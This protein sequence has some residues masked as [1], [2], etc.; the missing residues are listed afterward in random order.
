MNGY[1][2]LSNPI[3][4]AQVRLLGGTPR[5][6]MVSG[7]YA[8]LFLFLNVMFYRG[9]FKPEGVSLS[10]FAG[11]SLF[12]TLLIQCGLLF[13]GGPSA[14]KKAV[15]RDFTTEMITSHR[16]TA[17]T[18]NTAVLGYLTGPTITVC[19]LSVINWIAC[20]LLA[21]L[22]ACPIAAPTVIF[23]VFG[24]LAAMVWTFAVLV[25]LATRGV[26]SIVGVL[27]VVAIATSAQEIFRF[28]P[29]LA[30]LFS[31][32]T[33]GS[34]SA[35]TAS[36]AADNSILVSMMAQVLLAAIFF[37]AAARKFT[38]DDVAA[39]T[40][41]L[42]HALLAVCATV[43]ALGLRFWPDPTLGFRAGGPIDLSVQTVITLGALALIALLPVANAARQSA[44]WA[45]R[46]ALDPADPTPRPRPFYEAPI[47]ATL[48]VL[49]ILLVIVSTQVAVLFDDAHSGDRIHAVWIVA[50]FF[51]ALLQVAGL[52]RFTYAATPKGIWI[53]ALF[54][55]LVWAVPPIADV[56]LEVLEE[57]PPADPVSWLFG[58]SPVGT[59]ILSCTRLPGPILPGLAIQFSLAAATL[60]LARRARH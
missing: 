30:L 18:G 27:V 48:I 33:V 28:F 38:R 15:H 9:L 56:A 34:L 8:G 35:T 24:C 23:A 52:L 5:L 20:T 50:A 49:S 10:A 45:K 11:G 19:V 26:V 1:S 46:R 25:A 16:T 6:L 31:F 21:A 39:F 47:L 54:L 13:L 40:P 58:C 57:R 60:L 59:W 22:A 36:G 53:L 44:A 29:G 7:F 55:I 42:A 51:L 12:L 17:M 41:P 2:I 14:I 4:W 43:C 37:L 32:T 3:G